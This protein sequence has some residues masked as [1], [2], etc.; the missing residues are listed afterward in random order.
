MTRALGALCAAVLAIALTAPA[1]AHLP[2][3]CTG[4]GTPGVAL[5]DAIQEQMAQH[6]EIE[7]AIDALATDTTIALLVFRL[8]RNNKRTLG[9]VIKM[10]E[11]VDD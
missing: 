8:V 1:V 2:A 3:Q 7:A 11:C 5:A 4:E 10:L 9:H 6:A